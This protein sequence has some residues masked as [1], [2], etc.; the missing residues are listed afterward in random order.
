MGNNDAEINQDK[1]PPKLS[2]PKFTSTPVHETHNMSNL[3]CKLI[4]QKSK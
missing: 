3:L 2:S 4:Y 1:D